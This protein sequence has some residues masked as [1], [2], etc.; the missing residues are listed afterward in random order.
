MKVIATFASAALLVAVAV[1]AQQPTPTPSPQP[2]WTNCAK[3]PILN[4]NSFSASP[5]PLCHGK[6]VQFTATGSLTQPIIEGATVTVEAKWLRYTVYRDEFDLCQA[7][8]GAGTPCPVANI[9]TLK[10]S[11]IVDE[12]ILI[13]TPLD[14]R[15]KVY[16]GDG[17]EILCQNT[18]TQA[19]NCGNPPYIPPP[20]TTTTTT[21]RP[22]PTPVPGNFVP[23]DGPQN[24]TISS[25][26]FTPN[27]W[28]RG[29][30]VCVDISGTL[31]TNITWSTSL[32]LYTT[33][34]VGSEEAPYGIWD[35]YEYLYAKGQYN[36]PAGPISFRACGNVNMYTPERASTWELRLG[37]NGWVGQSVRWFPLTCL[38]ATNKF[39]IPPCPNA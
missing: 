7:L 6:P 31:K 13:G 36:I 21:K 29:S 8:A 15:V 27:A 2:S 9:D 33:D 11:S 38:K 39:E 5:L 12:R 20:V 1:T 10:F 26:T 22:I 34:V 18:T 19:S 23:C 30:N 4:V 25:A 14:L 35:F 3:N 32:H 28:C 37:Y 24:M 17:E 16:N